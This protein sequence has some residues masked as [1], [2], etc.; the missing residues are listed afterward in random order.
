[1]TAWYNRRNAIKLKFRSDVNVGENEWN[2]QNWKI[3]KISFLSPSSYS[4]PPMK[5]FANWNCSMKLRSDIF[6]S[7]PPAAFLFNDGR[8]NTAC[9]FFS[10]PW[11]RQAWE[12]HK[13][14]HSVHTKWASEAGKKNVDIFVKL[15]WWLYRATARVERLYMHTCATKWWAPETPLSMMLCANNVKFL[16]ISSCFFVGEHYSNERKIRQKWA[17][18]SHSFFIENFWIS[19]HLVWCCH[20]ECDN[21]P[22]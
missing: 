9:F 4:R 2:V 21:T 10:S 11:A 1:M 12:H 13:N 5:S 3:R 19:F 14:V 15:S 7:F 17:R 18:C 8:K 16:S 22:A 6:F 20:R